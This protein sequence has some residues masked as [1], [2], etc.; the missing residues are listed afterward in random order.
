MF[1]IFKSFA[2]RVINKVLTGFGKLAPFYVEIKYLAR[3]RLRYKKHNLPGRLIVSLTSYPPRFPSLH[4]T[5]K[6]L[7][8][9]RVRPDYVELWV[10]END[11]QALPGNVRRLEQDGLVIR[12]C[13]DLRSYKKIIPR[14]RESK[15]DWV[16]IADDDLYYWP[17]WLQEL[18][19]AV[20]PG[21]REVICS[22]CHKIEFTCPS[23]PAS[24]MEWSFDILAPDEKDVVFPTGIGGVL[25]PPGVFFKDV[26]DERLFLQLCPTGDDIWLFWMAAINGATFRRSAARHRLI[27]WD[28][29]Q[30]CALFN[31][32][33]LLDN[34]NDR[35]IAA[36]LQKYGWPFAMA[37][38]I[39]T[40]SERAG[41]ASGMM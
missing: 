14:L 31:Q 24:Y 19:A 21:K 39:E 1:A 23:V 12:R 38:E 16:A 35:Q 40:L 11:Y 10:A 8:M 25:Y 26:C 33:A 29:S 37:G 15:E 17:I 20:R 32:N 22:R 7:L 3:S 41:S 36:I 13:E 9:Q 5:L 34:H 2:V 30:E 18:V 6:S 4:L 28:G 27:L